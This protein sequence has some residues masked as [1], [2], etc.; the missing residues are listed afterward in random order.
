MLCPWDSPCKNTGV[1]CHALLQ[2]IFLMQGLNPHLLRLLHCRAGYLPLASPGKHTSHK[3]HQFNIHHVKVY[4]SVAFSI[5]PRT[6]LVAHC[7][8][9]A[10]Q[11]RRCKRLVFDPWVRKIPWRRKWQPTSV[12]LSGN[13]MDR[14]AVQAVV[15]GTAKESDVA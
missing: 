13:P 1:G 15:R 8:E 3:V 10:C 5:F 4:D 14:G 12:F 7:K 11:C 9:S 2:G 6:F